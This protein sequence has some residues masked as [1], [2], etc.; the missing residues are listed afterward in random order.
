MHVIKG[1]FEPILLAMKK[2]SEKSAIQMAEFTMITDLPIKDGVC[3]GTVGI[4]IQ[5]KLLIFR[6]ESTFLATGGTGQLF[7]TNLN[8][9]DITGN[10]YALGYRA[11]TELVNMEFMQAGLGI[12]Y[13]VKNI[14]NSWVRLLYPRVYN[15]HGKE[16][17]LVYLPKGMRFGKC[18]EARSNHDPFSTYDSSHYIDLAIQKEII[19]GLGSGHFGFF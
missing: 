17:L 18:M 16:F 19:S 4:D 7:L 1:H 5:N 11:G 9:I 3:Q 10:G 14:L 13:P 6:A 2:E 12:I 8:S 15:K